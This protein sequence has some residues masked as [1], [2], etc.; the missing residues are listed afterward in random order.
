MISVVRHG[1]NTSDA[2]VLPRDYPCSSSQGTVDHTYTTTAITPA[3]TL[4][5]KEIVS[6]SIVTSC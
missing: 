2:I 5:K 4:E 1:Q 3:P 6:Y